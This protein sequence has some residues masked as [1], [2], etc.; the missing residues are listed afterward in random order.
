MNTM[1]PE[2]VMLTLALALALATAATA[3][4]E[5][6]SLGTSTQELKIEK[7][8]PAPVGKP[9]ATD[10]CKQG[11]V[12]REARPSDHVCVTPQTRAEVARQN[13]EARRL[14]VNGAYGKHTCVQG[15]VWR[16]AFQGD[17]VC[18][19]PTVRDDTRRDNG[20]AAQRKVGAKPADVRDA[21]AKH[22]ENRARWSSYNFP[23]PNAKLM[24]YTILPSGHPACASY[25]GASCLW[26]VS[27]DQ[28]DFRRLRPLVCGEPHRAKWGVTGYE[29]PKHWC[30]MAR[31]LR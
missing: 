12:W 7:R 18:V 5:T 15:Y 23:A 16:E 11:Y 25:D 6:E 13:R 1:M 20:L 31:K 4:R 28:I 10:V 26:G 8:A 21:P 30:N 27:H 14:W 17:D 2:K 22:T 9:H 19:D 3:Q 29:D 24:T